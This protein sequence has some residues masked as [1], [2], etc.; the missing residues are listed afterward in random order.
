MWVNNNNNIISY[1]LLIWY[2]SYYSDCKCNIFELCNHNSHNIIPFYQISFN[3][4]EINQINKLSNTIN[5]RLE[6]FIKI[7]SNI[8]E[9]INKIKLIKGNSS[10]YENDQNNNYKQ[11]LID[12]LEVLTK[13]LEINANLVNINLTPLKKEYNIVCEYDIKKGEDDKN[14]YLNQIIINSFE[15][16]KRNF[17]WIK[18]GTNNEDEIK[19]N[20][21]LYLNNNKIDFYYKYKFPKDG[22]YKIEN[23]IKNPLSNTNYMFYHCNK[24]T[25]L[26]LSNFNTNNVK[27][28]SCMFSGVNR[29]KCK[30]ECE[31]AKILKEFS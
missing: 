25:S 21:E 2:N 5:E 17:D 19:E 29:K 8:E 15:E 3:Q 31:D 14:D 26:N 1:L 24:L 16:A 23:I 12:Y 7:K 20:C 11:Y 18:E 10:I 27:D 30:L 9:L 13:K 6:Q 22:K 4:N 28:M